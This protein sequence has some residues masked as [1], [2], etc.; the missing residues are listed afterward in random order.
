MRRRPALALAAAVLALPAALFPAGTA[1][2][3]PADKPL[4]LSSWTRTSTGSYHSWWSARQHRGTWRAYG[5]DWSTDYCSHAPDHPFGFPFRTSCARHDFGYRN[6]KAAGTFTSNKARL[7]SAF[8]ADMKRVCAAYVRAR[9]SSCSA[10]AWLY[11]QAV[12]KFGHTPLIDGG[13]GKAP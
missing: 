11:Y 3:V 1:V 6:Y 2:A 9:R 8:Y 12:R 5:F 13:A 7:D 10:T 4:V